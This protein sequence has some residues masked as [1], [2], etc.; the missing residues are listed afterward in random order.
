MKIAIIYAVSAG[1]IASK[2]LDRAEWRAPLR[3]RAP[4]EFGWVGA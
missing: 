1:R 2:G 3:E 4:Q